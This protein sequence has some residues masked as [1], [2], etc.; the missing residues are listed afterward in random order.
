[1][2]MFSG[3]I[4]V[5]LLVWCLSMPASRLA[6][7]QETGASD[8]SREFFEKKIRPALEEHCIRCH[9]AKKMQGGLRLD[10]REGWQKGG[11]SGAAIIPGDEESLLLKAISYED[12]SFEMPPRGKLP[13]KV[14]LV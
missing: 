1:M 4:V 9:G 11:D 2:W 3:K 10:S 7:A 6:R 12:A 13:E 8:A 5:I 14:S